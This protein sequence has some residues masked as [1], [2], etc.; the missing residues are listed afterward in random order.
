MKYLRRN[1]YPISTCMMA[2][3][4]TRLLESKRTLTSGHQVGHPVESKP[5][6]AWLLF[7]PPH[8][9]SFPVRL[10]HHKKASKVR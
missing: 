4:R 6:F 10:A 2:T 3:N 5:V 9:E 8:P 7:P 1:E